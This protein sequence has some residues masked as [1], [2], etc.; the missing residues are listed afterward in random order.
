MDRE[1]SL[2]SVP[3]GEDY[4]DPKRSR[5]GAELGTPPPSGIGPLP[6]DEPG[7]NRPSGLGARQGPGPAPGDTGKVRA[8]GALTR[9]LLA[10]GGAC[11]I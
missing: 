1:R 4:L 8:V 10:T 6:P 7:G 3:Q 5:P 9:E 2:R 11:L